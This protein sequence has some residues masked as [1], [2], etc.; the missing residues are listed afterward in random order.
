MKYLK[1]FNEKV[2][3]LQEEI[4]LLFINFIDDDG[5][6]EITDSEFIDL[7]QYMDKDIDIINSRNINWNSMESNNT[8]IGMSI[9]L[10]NVKNNISKDVLLFANEYLLDKGY[11][12]KFI[13]M[14]SNTVIYSNDINKID[15]IEG[16]D[17]YT[18]ISIMYEKL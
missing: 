5:I 9:N 13:C 7:Y 16:L 11:I 14:V 17:K 6:V 2:D 1:K 3:T 15:K 4:E 12:F 10:K 8:F 18:N